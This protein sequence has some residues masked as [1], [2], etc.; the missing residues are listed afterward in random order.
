MF[1]VK[2]EPKLITMKKILVIYFSRTGFTNG[3]AER[4]ANKCHADIEQIKIAHNFGNQHAIV[5]DRDDWQKNGYLQSMFQALVHAK[6]RI[7]HLRNSLDDYD[8]IIIGTPVWFWNMASPVRTL[9]TQYDFHHKPVAIFCTYGGSGAGKVIH[10]IENM[11]HQKSIASV[12][13][14]DDEILKNQC[15]EKIAAFVSKM[16]VGENIAEKFSVTA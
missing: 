15:E 2:S 14:T 13:L 12:A 5:A 9:I 7:G 16:N 3:I 6:P 4:I 10:D 1:F 11:L 8:L